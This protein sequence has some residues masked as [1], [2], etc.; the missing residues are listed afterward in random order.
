MK[1]PKASKSVKKGI[2]GLI[3]KMEKPLRGHIEDAKKS[4]DEYMFYLTNISMAQTQY[5]KER[6]RPD[7]DAARIADCM[8]LALMV[9]CGASY[10]VVLH[11][12]QTFDDVSGFLAAMEMINQSIE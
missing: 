1:K 5:H 4:G 2:K 8:L 9:H 7:A 6:G 3:A 12:A 10:P 11:L